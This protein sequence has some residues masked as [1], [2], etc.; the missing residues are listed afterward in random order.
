MATPDEIERRV[1]ENDSARSAKR[2]AASKRVGEL[3]QRRADI[4]DQL[5]D[6]ERELG[7]VLAEASDVIG[8]DELAKF[9]D[10]PLA[11]LNQWLNGRKSTRTKRKKPTGGAAAA[12]SDTSRGSPPAKTPTVPEPA[13]P[14]SDAADA[15]A[16][17]PAE[18]T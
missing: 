3:A 16:R 6:I 8:T 4:A 17:V 9:T 11:D 10:V 1:E 14:R 5:A 7:D 13:T 2:A 12:K 18:V 15:P